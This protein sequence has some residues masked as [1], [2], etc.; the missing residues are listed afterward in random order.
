VSHRLPFYVEPTDPPSKQELLKAALKLFAREGVRESS[1]R[2]VAKEA[3]FTNP[4]LFKYFDGKDALALHLFE[5]CYLRLVRETMG[6]LSE[7]GTFRARLG[8]LITRLL[9]LVDEAPE[10]VLF[11]NEELRRFWPQV[12]AATRR[13]SLVGMT[14]KFF[15]DEEVT[16]KVDRILLVAAFLG[17]LGQ[18]ARLYAFGEWKG[19]AVD[20]APQLET[21]LFKML[22]A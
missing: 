4:V 2:A 15:E 17:L 6:A 18:F 13:H 9:A 3:G 10:A 22:K 12:S 5:R 11:V 7:G 20:A 21:L 16:A 8:R 19:R 1:I 14:S